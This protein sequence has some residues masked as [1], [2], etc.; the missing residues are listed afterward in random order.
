MSRI[1][2]SGTYYAGA[3]P[4]GGSTGQALV[5][6]SNVD[7]D[8]EWG[9]VTAELP[10]GGTTGQ[11]LIKHSN[12]DQDVEWGDVDGLPAGGSQGQALIKQSSTDG[13]ANWEDIDA[14]PSGGTQGQ[15]L[16]KQSSTDGDAV[17]D[18]IDALPS[19]GTTG[20]ALVKKSN[21]DGDVEWDDVSSIPAGGIT[22]QVLAKHSNT[23]GD[24][25]WISEES[26]QVA[27][28]PAA[29]ASQDG[30]VVQFIGSSTGSYTHGYF[31]ECHAIPS[32]PSVF[33]WYDVPT[34]NVEKTRFTEMPT[35]SST[36]SGKIYQYIGTTSGG[37][38]QGYFY[39]CI[40]NSGTYQWVAQDVMLA[41]KSVKNG[42]VSL[43]TRDTLNFTDFDLSDDSTNLETIIKP[44]LVT[45]SEFDEIFSQL[46]N[47]PT[48]LPERGFTPVG[49]IIM[50][51][52]SVAPENYVLCD[53]TMYLI[54]QFPVLASHFQTQFGSKNY[55]GGD[56]TTTFAVPDVRPTYSLV[57]YVISTKNIFIETLEKQIYSADE[58]V[59]G[60]WIDNKPIYQK[61]F[62]LT[63]PAKST[64]ESYYATG[65]TI[66]TVVD[67]KALVY[68]TGYQWQ[69]I[70]TGN[71]NQTASNVAINVAVMSN[72][73]SSNK[74]SI[75]MFDNLWGS[76]PIYVTLQY[77]KTTD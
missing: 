34:Q 32:N 38:I 54:S 5:K 53:G 11:A 35:A 23:D 46:P 70:P 29:E 64:T 56:G 44:H 55:F 16:I 71:P 77:T 72:D 48:V 69:K 18:D 42:S 36:Y 26:I 40:N 4:T 31:Y 6:T 13:D 74:N 58:R 65:A 20:Q 73:A 41:I 12:M 21:A 50:V 62:S 30:K 51:T 9:S 10:A 45:S 8:V 61:T 3:F 76:R 15:A 47:V 57:S 7:G 67:I 60:Y 17:W 25:E 1:Y 19:G 24:V 22:G 43:V 63:T 75:R 68:S 49:T 66:D 59:V 27:T 52:G 28:M 2:K 33:S 14:L 39:E 37:F